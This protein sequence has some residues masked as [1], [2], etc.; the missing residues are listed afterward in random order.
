MRRRILFL[1]PRFPYPLIGGDRVKAYHLLRLL[2]ARHEVTCV[3]FNEEGDLTAEHRR[4]IADLGVELHVIP[5]SRAK[6]VARVALTALSRKPL[7]MQY[8]ADSK[9]QRTVQSLAQRKKLDVVIAF[10]MRTAEYALAIPGI[11]KIL[12][13]EDARLLTQRRS[14]GEFRFSP[15]YFMRVVERYK[16]KHYEPRIVGRF[17][18][19]TYVTEAEREYIMRYNPFLQA[20]IVTN[21]VDLQDYP[22]ASDQRH[23]EGLVLCGKMDVHHNIRMALR[24]GKEIFPQ[25]KK[26]YPALTF[27]IV[28]KNPVREI[29][30]L[31]QRTE[32]IIITGEVARVQGHIQSGAVFIHPFEAG[33]GIQ[34]KLLEAMALGTVAVTTPLGVSGIR[35][36]D[37][38]HCRIGETND[39]LISAC[40]RLLAAPPERARLAANA[41]RLIETE[42]SWNTVR[43][44]LFG[45]LEHVLHESRQTQIIA[46][47]TEA[48]L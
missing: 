47:P 9:F 29:R 43:E 41:R 33:S 28:G 42:H 3:T 15:G 18:R 5:I 24:V 23:R 37:A 38:V 26:L 11:P 16:L 1:T 20:S 7:E 25:L 27:R 31:A 4:A 40:A 45:V 46:T 8:Y 32:G 39:E 2:A 35:A 12:V 22:Y 48:M 44:Q 19:V 30:L 13:A 17:D 36:V 34:N 21:G 14:T 6:A 10:F